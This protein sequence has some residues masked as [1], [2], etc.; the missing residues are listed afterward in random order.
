MTYT[1]LV[2]TLRAA[3][4]VFA[5]DEAELLLDAVS[6]DARSYP[7]G[8]RGGLAELVARRV[9]GEPLEY[10]LGW[11][12][13]CGLQLRIDPGVFVP[14]QRTELLVEQARLLSPDPAVVL[15]LCCG[16]GALGI[17]LGSWLQHV[18]LHAVDIEQ[19]AVE[20]AR[21]NVGM[22]GEVYLGDLFQPLPDRLRGRIDM[23]LANVPYVPTAA[24]AFMPAEARE[25]EPLVTLDGGV[26]GQDVMRRVIAEA[27]AWLAP[28]GRLLIET[29]TAQAPAALD[30]LAAAGLEPALAEDDERGATV[31]I[32]RL[33]DR[34]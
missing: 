10:I 1:E 14:R 12:E 6:A 30:L 18:E 21:E 5:E 9:A 19:A 2:E 16:C 24:I 13:F 27:P 28:G 3:G 22:A 7:A 15:D 25:H 34:L 32:G 29:S 33:A 8:D 11:V 26:D 31:I 23:L 17:A 20:C 4:C